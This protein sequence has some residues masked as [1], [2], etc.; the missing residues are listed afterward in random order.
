MA[1]CDHAPLMEHVA[2][3]VRRS[4][5]L[6]STHWDSCPSCSERRSVSVLTVSADGTMVHITSYGTGEASSAS[7]WRYFNNQWQVAEEE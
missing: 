6:A 1:R 2:P 3:L 4:P 5:D 7:I